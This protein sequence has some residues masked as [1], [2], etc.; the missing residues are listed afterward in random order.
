MREVDPIVRCAVTPTKSVE[1]EAAAMSKKAYKVLTALRYQ[2]EGPPSQS[3]CL[4]LARQFRLQPPLDA[5]DRHRQSRSPFPLDI[6]R[7]IIFPLFVVAILNVAERRVV[8]SFAL[9]S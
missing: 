9:T 3:S 8:G 6:F 2:F 5:T 1:E 4:K 7:V